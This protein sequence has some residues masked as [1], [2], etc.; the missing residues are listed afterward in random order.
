MRLLLLNPNT[1]TALTERMAAV[2]RGIAADGTVIDA[3]TAPRGVPYIATR[4]E[5]AIGGAVALEML[6]ERNGTFDAVIMAAFGDPALHA[7][8]ELLSVPVVGLAE[9]AMLTAGMLGRRFS[10]VTFSPTLAAWFEECAAAAG[11]TARLV[12]LRIARDQFSA[13][14]RVQDE[15]TE[16]LLDAAM[17]AAREDGAEVIILGGAPLAGLARKLAARLPVPVIDSVEAATRMAE[18]LVL[19]RPRKAEIGSFRRPDPK[20]STGLPPALAALLDGA[21]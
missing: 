7:A 6:A 13:I 2:A 9:A 1:T 15:M 14:D 18:T 5:A 16:A 4:A 21:P 19:L 3:V 8:R 10:I 12:S 20:P 17:G 11:M